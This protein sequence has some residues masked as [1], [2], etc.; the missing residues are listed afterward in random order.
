MYRTMLRSLLCATVLALL[1]GHVSTAT[2][3]GTLFVTD[4]N[5]DPYAQSNVGRVLAFDA[6]TGQYLRTV[7]TGLTVPSAVTIGPGGLLYVTNSGTGQVL[8][9]NPSSNNVPASSGSVYASGIFAPGGLLYDRSD[10]SMFVSQLAATQTGFFGEDVY[11]FNSS[12]QLVT[13]DGT[14][15]IIGVG[16]GQ[17]GR[18]GMALDSNHNLYVGTFDLNSGSILEFTAASHYVNSSTFATQ[19]FGAS[20]MVFRNGNLLVDA[21]FEGA[22]L[23]YDSSGNFT[24]SNPYIYLGSSAFNSGLI[25][26]GSNSLF[27]SSIGSGTGPG[28]IGLYNIDTGAPLHTGSDDL[29]DMNTLAA[30]N[31]GTGVPN[32]NS[33]QPSSAFTYFLPGDFNLDGT[34]TTADIQSMMQALTNPNGFESANDLSAD[35][36]AQLGDLNGDGKFNGADLQ[37]LLADLKGLPPVNAPEP[38]S[39]LLAGISLAIVAFQVRGRMLQ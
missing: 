26:H 8:S 27:V 34:R 1:I 16:S 10:N 24:P 7:V 4:L 11:H 30:A 33:F 21:Q 13:T 28:Q 18:A 2:A 35:E 12:G 19:A 38:S 9:F 20:Q 37:T 23:Q 36:L 5:G 31:G 6:T 39:L 17:T 32:T 15:G 3:A 14:G 22:V 29:I 25:G